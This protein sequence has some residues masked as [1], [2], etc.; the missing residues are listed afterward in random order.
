MF[1]SML[2]GGPACGPGDG[3]WRVTA[4][5]LEAASAFADALLGFDPDEYSGEDCAQIVRSLSAV[6]KACDAARA[7]AAARA[8]ACGAHRR[9][10]FL[11]P[12][13]WFSRQA[14]TTAGQARRDRRTAE[15]VR[16]QP[17]TQ[18]ALRTGRL[19]MGQADE[20]SRT[21]E[22]CPQAED[23]LLGQAGTLALPEL[24]EEAR[25]IREEAMDPAELR[26]RQH[27]ARHFRHWTDPLGMIRFTGALTPEV[28]VAFVNR[29]DEDTR[30]LR[31]GMPVVG[32]EPWDATAA[33]AFATM[34]DPDPQRQAPTRRGTTADVVLVCDYRAFQRGA[35]APGER[36]HIIGGSRTTVEVVRSWLEQDAFLK[37]VLHDGIKIDTVKH[38]G[39]H[40]SAELRT[41][42][43]LGP[44][45]LFT[46]A[47]CQCGCG[48]RYGLQHDHINPVAN[49]GP[50]SLDNL[51]PLTSHHHRLK[52]EQD[53]AAGLLTGQKHQPSGHPGRT[54][55]ADEP[56]PGT[57][58]PPDP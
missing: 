27:Q 26:A 1:H 28:G 22:Q 29:L 12:D 36:C 35:A 5:V 52:T 49:D 20:I 4:A 57:R 25:R 15:R 34:I 38:F 55:G 39:R 46:G 8:A 7:L 58:A 18:E 21:T 13:E 50:T 53:R 9:D 37:A 42:L 51:Q 45:P 19:S 14:G 43:A 33:D 10:G 56:E 3:R 31:R 32:R 44:P 30:R 47:T 40:I 23:D 17:K 54:A 6:A 48:G 41:A 2:P 24:R 11:D 16:L